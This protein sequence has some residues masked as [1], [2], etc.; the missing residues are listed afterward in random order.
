MVWVR[1]TPKGSCLTT[2][3]LNDHEDMTALGKVEETGFTVDMR[4]RTA[5]GI[6]KSPD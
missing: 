4:E 5:R 6:C 1:K 2:W 3:S